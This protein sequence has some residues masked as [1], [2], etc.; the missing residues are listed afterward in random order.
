LIRDAVAASLA[1]F[2]E[3][4]ALGMVTFIDRD[5]VRPKLVRGKKTWG[6]TWLKAGF[7]IA[8][9]TKGGLLALQLVPGA[10]PAPRAAR[11]RSVAGLP[12][13]DATPLPGA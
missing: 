2:G 5:A 1:H 8:G 9:E 11:P 7:T 13:F 10:M 3:A 6:W 4:P 12:L